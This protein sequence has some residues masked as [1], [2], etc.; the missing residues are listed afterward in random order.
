MRLKNKIPKPLKTASRA[1]I[2]PRASSVYAYFASE[3]QPRDGHADNADQ[4]NSLKERAGQQRQAKTRRIFRVGPLAVMVFILLLAI[5]YNSTL[6]PVVSLAVADP[7]GQPL[8]RPV[9][10]YKQAART[11]L[12][13]SPGNGTKFSI[14]TKKFNAAFKSQFPELQ[15]VA[16]VLPL[17]GRSPTLYISSAPPKLL[18]S[19]NSKVYVV[20]ESGR[21]LLPANEVPAETLVGIPVMQDDSGLSVKLGEPIITKD[22]VQFVQVL[23]GQ[24]DAQNKTILSMQL[25]ALANELRVRL[26]REGYY[27]KFDTSGNPRLQAGTYFAVR[28]KL[29]ADKQTPQEYIDVRVEEKAFY[30]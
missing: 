18:V 2:P 17:V 19:S 22:M 26:D 6:S 4:R 20:D 11:L 16:I 25:P 3:K 30:K 29:A 9:Q 24:F 7:G 12:E 21:T 1:V 8:Y 14:D 10:V 27:I 15:R 23:R 5:A 13:N 28:E